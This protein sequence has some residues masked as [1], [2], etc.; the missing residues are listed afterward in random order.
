MSEASQ[1]RPSLLCIGAEGEAGTQAP[2]DLHIPSARMRPEARALAPWRTGGD[3]A[4][5]PQPVTQL[6]AAAGACPP[7]CGLR[8][9]VFAEFAAGGDEEIAAEL[10]WGLEDDAAGLDVYLAFHHPSCLL[11]PEAVAAVLPGSAIS[12]RSTSPRHA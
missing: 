8:A 12:S 3:F 7:A 4:A 2:I 9:H 1:T 5:S 10:P 11:F 6:E